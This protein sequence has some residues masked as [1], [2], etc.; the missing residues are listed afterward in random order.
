M[1]EILLTGT[2]LSS[3]NCHSKDLVGFNLMCL[4]AC[5]RVLNHACLPASLSVRPE[6]P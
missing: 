2:F 6:L 1:T 3:I 4:P 5:I